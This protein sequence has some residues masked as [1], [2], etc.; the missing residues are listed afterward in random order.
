MDTINQQQD[1]EE[2]NDINKT[3]QIGHQNTDLRAVIGVLVASIIKIEVYRSDGVSGLTSA[4]DSV[5]ELRQIGAETS[6]Y[7]DYGTAATEAGVH[8][9]QSCLNT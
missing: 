6:V 3:K 5:R 8:M 1:Q 7:E 4:P 9:R 2:A